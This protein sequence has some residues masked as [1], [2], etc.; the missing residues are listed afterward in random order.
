MRTIVKVVG[1][2]TRKK[3]VSKKD[4]P[5]D[6]CDIAVAYVNQWGENAVAVAT[7]DGP[8][9]DKLQV[10]VG[11]QYDAVVNTYNYKT[12]VDLIEEAL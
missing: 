9:L 6:L 3:G 11:D 12:Y 7:L 1:M 5:F 10:Q 4:K 2:G 8:V